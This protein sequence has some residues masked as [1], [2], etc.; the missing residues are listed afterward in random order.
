M[1][2]AGRQALDDLL[3]SRQYLVFKLNSVNRCCDNALHRL[4]SLDKLE[5]SILKPEQ[6]IAEGDF[7]I[8]EYGQVL[9]HGVASL[10]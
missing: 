3:L 9:A 6:L 7:T 1:V 4:M 10:I 5:L 2:I 8:L